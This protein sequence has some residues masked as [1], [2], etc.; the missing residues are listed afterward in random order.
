MTINCKGQL[1]DLSKPK[2]MGILNL[3][4]NSFFDGGKYLD[5]A[6]IVAQVQKMLSE[7]AAFI[8]IGAYDG[9]TISNTYY[10]EKNDTNVLTWNSKKYKKLGFAD[11]I[12]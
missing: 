4:P 11:E 9:I 5:E 1:I 7:G 8:D 6:A 12:L 10:F 2:V 3:T